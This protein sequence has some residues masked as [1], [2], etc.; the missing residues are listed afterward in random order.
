[1]RIQ[2]AIII[3][4]IH[5]NKMVNLRM[6]QIVISERVEALLTRTAAMFENE[7]ITTS[8]SDRLAIELLGDETSR[9][10]NILRNLAGEHGVMVIMRRI[11]GAVISEPCG[12][13]LAPECHYGDMC[14]SLEAMLT[15]SKLS[16]AHL[17]YAIASDATTHTARVLHDYGITPEDILRELGNDASGDMSHAESDSEVEACEKRGTPKIFEDASMGGVGAVEHHVRT[18]LDALGHKRCV[19]IVVGDS[20]TDRV[21]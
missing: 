4:V 3:L 16:T 20:P 13:Q 19:V 17:L 11:V 12:E 21:A 14:A 1:M 8:F 5:A 2:Y 15:P 10:H 9:A 7:A 6:K 18:L